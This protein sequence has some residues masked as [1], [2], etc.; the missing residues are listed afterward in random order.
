MAG[1]CVGQFL[2][3]P[4]SPHLQGGAA[5]ASPGAGRRPDAAVGPRGA[6]AVCSGQGPV[7]PW[8]P[9]SLNRAWWPL[10]IP[11]KCRKSLRKDCGTRPAIGA[12]S[13]VPRAPWATLPTTTRLALHPRAVRRISRLS[14]GF[15]RT[16]EPTWLNSRGCDEPPLST[17][18]VNLQSPR[19]SA[20]LLLGR[21]RPG[22]KP[23]RARAPPYACPV[24]GVGACP[25]LPTRGWS[26]RARAG[27]AGLARRVEKQQ[28]EAARGPPRRV[29]PQGRV[30]AAAAGSAAEETKPGS[31][32]TRW[33]RWSFA[34]GDQDEKTATGQGRAGRCRASVG[35]P[36]SRRGLPHP[37]A[38]CHQAAA[39]GL[40][41]GATFS[42][43]KKHH[44]GCAGA[45]RRAGR[46]SAS[47]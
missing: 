43:P 46:S 12:P 13:Q 14:A 17:W 27:A 47:G 8:S 25:R 20:L 39:Q 6:P 3:G 41:G 29:R 34:H 15:S 2:A 28:G 5:K 16:P 9:A 23:P 38:G 32:P 10:G 42:R 33:G 36:E 21:G 18:Q 22:A 35:T 11:L 37:P 19:R 7:I 4:W 45:A 1:P 30:L 44:E 26:G 31:W 24:A 40:S